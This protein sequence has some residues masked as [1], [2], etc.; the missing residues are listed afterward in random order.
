[1]QRLIRKK[2]GNL[3]VQLLFSRG[4]VIVGAAG[5][6]TALP[7]CAVV[8]A[9]DMVGTVAVKTVGLAADAAIGVVKITGHAV[10]SAVNVIIPNGD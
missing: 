3:A 8:A 2:A 5:C 1:M 10:G 4:M 7:G 6:L 9:V